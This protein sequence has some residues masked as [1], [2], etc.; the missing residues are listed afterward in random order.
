MVDK[1]GYVKALPDGGYEYG[2]QFRPAGERRDLG[3]PQGP[4][5]DYDT[6]NRRMA[7][8]LPLLLDYL[9]T[10][11]YATPGGSVSNWSGVVLAQHSAGAHDAADRLLRK[12]RR[13]ARVFKMTIHPAG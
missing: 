11:E 2:A 8:V 9:A 7:E 13:V 3:F 4:V 6:A 12:Q 5:A 10:A 1:S